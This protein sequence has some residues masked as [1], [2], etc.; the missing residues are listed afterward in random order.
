MTR[1]SFLL[2]LFCCL[3]ILSPMQLPAE[4]AG[5]AE[6]RPGFVAILDMDMMI[7]PGTLAYLD[8]SLERAGVEGASLVIVQL[9]TPGG[10]L[11]SS[12]RM[13]QSLLKSKVP[14]VVYVS[15]GGA[16]AASAGVFITL[17]GHV[18]AMAPGTTIGAAHPVS[19]DGKN[20]EGDMRAKV[21]N[22]TIAMVK[23]ISEQRGRNVE[24]AEKSVKESSSVTEVEALKIGVVDIV[25]PN[26]D[27]LL[28]QL[29]GREVLLDGKKA[30][31]PDFSGL[32]RRPYAIK[33]RD[34]VLNVLANPNVAALLWLGATT[35]ISIELYNP[36]AILPGVVGV[37]CLVLALAVG[38]VIPLNSGAILLMAVGAVLIGLEFWVP[39]GILGLGG[40]AAIAI[41]AL[42]LVDAGGMPGLMAV[43]PMLI[44]P[45]AAF[46][47]GLMFFVVSR[48]VKVLRRRPTTGNDGMLGL[49]GFALEC[50]SDTGK[51]FVNGE[52]WNAFSNGGSIPKGSRI[53]VLSVQSGM[54]LEVKMI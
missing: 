32:E 43:D 41:G 25:A 31:L 22:M 16:T 13:T 53:E 45:L 5:S 7:L 4:E 21:E 24:W 12:Q 48:A 37:I 50:I 1:L 29:K 30:T 54:R 36:G 26:L 33:A 35:G 40:V 39:S 9:N 2:A 10:I 17:A 42:Y 19:G 14:V 23:A 34:A 44:L 28:R 6:G 52:T 38:Q 15:P 18:A 27:D 51:V 47:G 8:A 20:I 3:S 46:M 49:A 11:E